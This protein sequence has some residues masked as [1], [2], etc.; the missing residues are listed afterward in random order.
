MYVVPMS[1]VEDLDKNTTG[2]GRRRKT[3][4]NKRK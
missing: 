4:K 2:G 3:L 1:E